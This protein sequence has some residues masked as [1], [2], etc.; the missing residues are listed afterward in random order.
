MIINER[1]IQNI[2]LG[3]D[4]LR[5]ILCL[6]VVFVHYV[7]IHIDHFLIKKG[8]HVPTFFLLSFYLYYKSLSKR[9][10]DK[11][12]NRFK[13]ILIP[14]IGW[15]I[16]IYI[17]NNLFIIFF[18]VGIYQY[19]LRIK[20]VFLQILTGS[21]Y[22]K[23]FWFQF[24]LIF[25]SLF[26]TIF[27]FFLKKNFLLSL[28]YFGIIT[29]YIHISNFNHK[30]I[31]HYC[32]KN[33]IGTFGPIIELFPLASFGCILSSFDFLQKFRLFS[34]RSLLF[35]LFLLYILFKYETFVIHIGFK[36]STKNILFNIFVC[37]V[38][39]LLFSCLKIENIKYLQ[40]KKIIYIITRYTGGIYYIHYIFRDVLR[41]YSNYYKKNQT[42]F[43]VFIIYIISYAICFIG[44]KIFKNNK[45]KCLFI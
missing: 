39:L 28:Y 7:D 36:A 44:N 23:V 38:L 4:I 12:V 3:I 6:W 22:Y 5:V 26:L 37:P 31:N 8:V 18:S 45:L 30:I 33:Y 2:D 21:I 27:S 13:R 35:L 9:Y 10:I 43:S 41:K 14:Y 24:N 1:N 15:V 25:I 40:I 42:V 29:Y 11:I 34:L 19:K 16:I 20:D 17:I 32:T